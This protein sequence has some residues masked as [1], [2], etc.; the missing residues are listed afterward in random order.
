MNKIYDEGKYR[1]QNDFSLEKLLIEVREMKMCLENKNILSQEL[2]NYLKFMDQNVIDL[3]L[4]SDEEEI[5]Q[6]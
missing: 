1:I 5:D 6:I 3:D 4:V 2:K